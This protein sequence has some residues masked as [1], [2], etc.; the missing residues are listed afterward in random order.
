MAKK[1]KQLK[2]LGKGEIKNKVQI[3]IN[4]ISNSAKNKIEKSGGK[5]IMLSNK[6]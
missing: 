6:K 2:L 1:Y 4:S 3:E 5:I